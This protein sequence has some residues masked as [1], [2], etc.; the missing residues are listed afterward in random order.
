[1]DCL[2]T[3]LWKRVTGVDYLDIALWRGS[4]NVSEIKSSTSKCATVHGVVVGELSPVKTSSKNSAMKYF[5]GRFGDGTKTV[6]LVS[7]DSTLRSKLEDTMKA[8]GGVA[9]QNCMIKRKAGSDEFELHVNNKS[10]VVNSLS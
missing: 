8:G 7:F 5:D 3:G 4:M 2:E 10:V 1:M 9:L 6:R